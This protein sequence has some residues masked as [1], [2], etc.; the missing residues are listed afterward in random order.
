M[1]VPLP[2]GPQSPAGTETHVMALDG[3]MGDGVQI[4]S[5][6]FSDSRRTAAG[7][8]ARLSMLEF[9]GAR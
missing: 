8:E 2:R 1:G 5:L 3:I 4:S 6:Y 9:N 7:L